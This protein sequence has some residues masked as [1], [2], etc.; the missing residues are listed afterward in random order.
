MKPNKAAASELRRAICLA[1]LALVPLAAQA[2]EP[3]SIEFVVEGGK[4]VGG[5]RVIRLTRNDAVQLVVRSDKADELH[6]HG[7]NLHAD[8]LPNKPATLK[9]VASRTGRFSAEL[10]GSGVEL[11]VL[12]IYPK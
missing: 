5:S 9:F 4:V 11:G 10:H 2:A 1:F 8:L 7:Y 3:V 6:L 12:E